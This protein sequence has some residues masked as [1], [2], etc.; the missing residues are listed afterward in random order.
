MCPLCIVPDT[1]AYYLQ[2]FQC[3]ANHDMQPEDQTPRTND[4]YLIEMWEAKLVLEDLGRE[5]DHTLRAQW[6]GR[7]HPDGEEATFLPAQKGAQAAPENQSARR[8]PP[9]YSRRAALAQRIKH[10]DG[11]CAPL[12]T[13]RSE[14]A[15]IRDDSVHVTRGNGVAQLCRTAACTTSGEEPTRLGAAT[16]QPRATSNPTQRRISAEQV[17]AWDVLCGPARTKGR[18]ALARRHT[19]Q[20]EC[21]VPQCDAR[22]LA[23]QSRGRRRA[24]TVGGEANQPEKNRPSIPGLGRPRL[25]ARS[26]KAAQARIES[27]IRDGEP[28]DG[29]PNTCAGTHGQLRREPANKHY[30]AIHGMTC[31]NH[32]SLHD[33]EGKKNAATKRTGSL[34]IPPTELRRSAV[35]ATR[36]E[37]VHLIDL[38]LGEELRR[39]TDGKAP[40]EEEAPRREAHLLA[41]AY[42]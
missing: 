10:L 14:P 7:P 2:E 35:A 11:P 21:I 3:H 6:H 30:T 40:Q 34:R 17:N 33:A 36:A 32:P 4:D 39:G 24:A 31:A 12:R 1:L 42:T 15:L 20:P 8:R 29:F 19:W 38:E 13:T 26:F 27:C 16:Q 28:L 22:V 37:A 25:R 9:P 41:S 5:G 23:H 18:A